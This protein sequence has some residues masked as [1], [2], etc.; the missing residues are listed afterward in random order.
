MRKLDVI[1]VVMD[2]AGQAPTLLLRE[3]D[4]PRQLSI[5]VGHGEARAILTAL[6][7]QVPP[8]PLT[9]DL[10]AELLTELGHTSSL[11][12]RLT[13]CTDGVFN[14]EL[15]VDGHVIAARPSDLVALAVR[16]GMPLTCTDELLAQVGI[17]EEPV[18]EDDV[19]K[20]REFLDN[21]NAD[22]FEA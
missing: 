5:W 10:L 16:N 15:H 4:G 19:E 8:R 2:W 6:E 21:V 1:G 17:T 18:P 14:A 12:G 9:H 7:G 11:E 20:F 3:Q 22:D 13:D